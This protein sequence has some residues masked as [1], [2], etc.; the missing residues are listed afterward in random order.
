MRCSLNVRRRSFLGLCESSLNHLARLHNRIGMIRPTFQ[1]LGMIS[2]EIDM[3]KQLV[4]DDVAY[5]GLELSM[6]F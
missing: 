6:T 2:V 3:Y 1:M 4:R 5:V